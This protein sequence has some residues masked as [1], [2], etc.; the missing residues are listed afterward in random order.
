[1]R[2]EDLAA[3]VRQADL[4]AVEMSRQDEVEASRL[5]QVEHARVVAEENREVGL[6]VQ[7]GDELV[8]VEPRC[9]A[10]DEV[11]VD[12]RDPDLPAAQ[13]HEPPLVAK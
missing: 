12:A 13:L 1:M 11:R 8:R 6:D 5:E 3:R 10:E 9:A 4:A 7:R 2:E